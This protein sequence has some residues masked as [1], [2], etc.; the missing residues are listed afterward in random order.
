[1]M[2]SI[3]VYSNRSKGHTI[4]LSYVMHDFAQQPYYWHI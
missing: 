2:S 3:H 4:I 1:M